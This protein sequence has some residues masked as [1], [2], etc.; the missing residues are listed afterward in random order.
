MGSVGTFHPGGATET[1][2]EL[3]VEVEKQATLLCGGTMESD[4]A[5]SGMQCLGSNYLREV[6]FRKYSSNWY[7]P[8]LALCQNYL[9]SLK[10]F[11]LP[12][13]CQT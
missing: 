5:R 8:S 2:K 10:E 11:R 4:V 6:H 7:L 9:E 13:T 1:E 12:G 3:L